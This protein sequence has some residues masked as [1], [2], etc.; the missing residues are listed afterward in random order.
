MA[1]QIEADSSNIY[2]GG[3]G[4]YKSIPLDFSLSLLVTNVSHVKQKLTSYQQNLRYFKTLFI[5]KVVI[6]VTKGMDE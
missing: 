2:I 3:V 5:I 4:H 6:I 1:V